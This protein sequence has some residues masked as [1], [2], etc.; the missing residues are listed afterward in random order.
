[1]E[2]KLLNHFRSIQQISDEEIDAIDETLTVKYLKKGT[3]LL[4]EGQYS[5]DVYFV[6][7][8]VVRHYYIVDGTEKTSDFFIEGQWVLSTNT[9]NHNVASSHF[10]ECSLDC[11]LIIGDSQKGEHLYKKYPN[12][13]TIS[14]KLMNQVFIE[15]QTK[16]ETYILDTPKERYLKLLKSNPELFQKLPQYQIA[17]YVG[18]TP[19]S[20]SRIRKRIMQGK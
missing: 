1:M 13:E 3:L 11:K 4:K 15:Q 14:R 19:E 12:L 5:S 8:G 16:M 20:L 2:D 9:V 17:S 10:L 6:L 7:E 18:V